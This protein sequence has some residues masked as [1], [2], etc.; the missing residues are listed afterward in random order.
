MGRALLL[1]VAALSLAGIT[2]AVTQQGVRGELVVREVNVQHATL[3]QNAARG[4][5]DAALATVLSDPDARPT[6]VERAAS[7]DGDYGHYSVTASDT[8]HG[9]VRLLAQGRFERVGHLIEADVLELFPLGAAVYIDAEEAK[10]EVDGALVSGLDRRVPGAGSGVG[11]PAGARLAIGFRDAALQTEVQSDWDSDVW[12]SLEGAGPTAVAPIPGSV[13]SVIDAV[14]AAPTTMRRTELKLKHETLG[15]PTA[16]VAVHVTEKAEFELDGLGYGILIIDGDLKMKENA[17]WEGL[18]VIRAEAGDKRKVELGGDASIHGAL[19]MRGVEFLEESSG[20]DGFPGGHMDLDLFSGSGLPLDRDYHQ[21]EW[22]DRFDLTWLDFFNG[23]DIGPEFSAFHARYLGAG[24][25]DDD[26]SG[27]TLRVEFMNDHSAAGTY[28]IGSLAS[29]V[30]G[31][32]E[33]GFDANVS[34][35]S[36]SLFQVRFDALCTLRGTSPGRVDDD[37]TARDEAFTVR[38]WD[39]TE[40]VYAVTAYE[41]TDLLRDGDP[42]CTAG[43]GST[44]QSDAYGTFELKVK[45]DAAVYYS[46]EALGRLGRGIPAVRVHSR[47]FPMFLRNVSV[48]R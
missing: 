40:L 6:G 42:S 32:I 7:A 2:Y 19:V 14:L 35:G 11:G 36:L 23:P 30:T 15:S 20:T 26:G 9:T 48:P 39:G 16:P 41:H 10:V 37:V 38:F 45:D 43:S 18:I 44:Q 24:G 28:A 17:R 1:I 4:G 27:G 12:S 3:A 5:F 8:P 25:D 21:H 13:V 34:F 29:A 46:E 31:R 22:D 33:D 47:A